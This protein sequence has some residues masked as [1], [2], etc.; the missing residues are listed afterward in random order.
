V[1]SL[2]ADH[3]TDVPSSDRHTVKPWFQGKLDYGVP[4]ADFAAQGFP[5][6]GGRLDVL[7][8][9]PAAA[10]VYRRAKHVINLFV[11]P[12]GH[13]DEHVSQ[14]GYGAYFWSKGDMQY[15]AISD[16]NDPEL[17]QFVDLARRE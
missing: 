12:G 17:R 7:D 14:R 4:V 8:G 13:A 1:R 10:L 6:V 16:L 15:C 9:K 11:W 3:L 5:L 2:M